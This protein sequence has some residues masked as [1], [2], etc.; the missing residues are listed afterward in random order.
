MKRAG[1]TGEQEFKVGK[2][3]KGARGY[4]TLECTECASRNYR[5]SKRLSGGLPKLDLTKFCRRC[6]AHV[7]HKERKK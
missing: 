2:K 7:K 6:R 1:E 3:S 4:I 5:T